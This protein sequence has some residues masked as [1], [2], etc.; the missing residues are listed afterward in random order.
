MEFLILLMPLVLLG[1]LAFVVLYFRIKRLVRLLRERYPAVFAQLRGR[2]RRWYD[3]SEEFLV[4]QGDAR[5]R[6]AS[7]L[8]P[9]SVNDKDLTAARAD[10]SRPSACYAPPCSS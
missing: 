2:E 6:L 3:P 4:L 10:L 7:M 1:D 8:A 9:L 5:R